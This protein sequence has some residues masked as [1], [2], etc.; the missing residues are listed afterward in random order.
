MKLPPPNHL[1]WR[2]LGDLE[3]FG[4]EARVLLAEAWIKEHEGIVWNLEIFHH[5][6]AIAHHPEARVYPNH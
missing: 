4:P 5:D 2:L 6:Q 3:G 1:F